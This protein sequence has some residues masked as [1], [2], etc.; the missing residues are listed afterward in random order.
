MK[1]I[2]G[3]PGYIVNTQH[4]NKIISGKTPLPKD[5][6]A[7]WGKTEKIKTVN[8]AGNVTWWAKNDKGELY[9]FFQDK[10]GNVHFSGIINPREPYIPKEVKSQLNLK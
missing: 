7:V 10:Q 3:K 8:G 1:P 5:A 6:E 9:R 2:K 4:T